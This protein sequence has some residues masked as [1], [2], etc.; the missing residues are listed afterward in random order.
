MQP[1][2]EGDDKIRVEPHKASISQSRGGTS[3]IGSADASVKKVLNAVLALWVVAILVGLTLHRGETNSLRLCYIYEEW[4]LLVK[5][6]PCVF[7]S[8]PG[9]S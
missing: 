1:L 9:L 2:A 5:T 6:A 8:V 3:L 4:S 7:V